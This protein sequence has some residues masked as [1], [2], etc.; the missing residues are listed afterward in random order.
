MYVGLL[1]A[2]INSFL[3]VGFLY[4]I[5]TLT[6]NVLLNIGNCITAIC[7]IAWLWAWYHEAKLCF[8]SCEQIVFIKFIYTL[9]LFSVVELDFWRKNL[10]KLSFIF[11]RQSTS[12]FYWIVCKIKKISQL[13]PFINQDTII[14]ISYDFVLNV[15]PPVK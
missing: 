3:L 12:T 11:L 5:L 2:L 14:H 9:K 15:S 7:W 13:I 6:P 1:S 4:E 10:I 8:Q